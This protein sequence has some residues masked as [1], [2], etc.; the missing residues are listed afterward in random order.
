MIGYRR[1]KTGR[2]G[3]ALAQSYLRAKSIKVI[4]RNYRCKFGEIDLIARQ[5]DTIIFI[6]VKTRTHH[7]F[8]PPEASV[9]KAKQRKIIQVALGYLTQHELHDAP[10]RFDVIGITLMGNKHRLNHIEAAFDASI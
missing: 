2:R 8:G 1:H 9:T 4:D 5:H 10:V 3:E 6:E 7:Q